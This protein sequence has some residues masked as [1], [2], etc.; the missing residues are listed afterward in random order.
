MGNCC[1]AA[2]RATEISVASPR[3]VLGYWVTSQGQGCL[4][5]VALPAVGAKDCELTAIFTGVSKGTERLVGMGR[6][7]AE[8][9][10]PMACRGMQGNMQL[11]VLYGYSFV[12]RLTAGEH[13]GRIAFTMHP[14][15]E[16]AVV[17]REHLVLLPSGMPPSRATLFPNLETAWNAM[18]DAELVAGERVAVVGGGAVGLLL[19]FVL[20]SVLGMRVVLVESDPLRRSRAARLPWAVEVIDPA[21][22]PRGTFDA[23][24]HATGR[25]EGL[26]LAIDALGFE[27]RVLDLSWYGTTKV[28]VR[29]GGRFHYQRQRIIA[30]QVATVARVHRAGGYAARTAAVLELLGDSRLDSLFDAPIPF[31]TLPEF[32]ARLYH[33]DV[34]SP[35]PLVS[36]PNS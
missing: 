34:E 10:E 21:D 1:S 28:S 20:Q 18:W 23:V 4:R 13:A 35:C 7:P 36:Y 12:G 6:V 16:R 5:D 30:S 14:H 11:P 24:F 29:L 32:F 27:G 22:L 3:V 17:A 31:A 33:G 15:Q 9:A 25:G 2:G 19:T 8:C 26:Q